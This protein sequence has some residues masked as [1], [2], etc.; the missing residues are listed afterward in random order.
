M[1]KRPSAT[2]VITILLAI[3]LGTTLLA[4][5]SHAP[6]TTTNARALP[7]STDVP[8]TLLPRHGQ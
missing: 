1:P 7:I 5:G 4:A 3:M 6:P 2:S 8:N